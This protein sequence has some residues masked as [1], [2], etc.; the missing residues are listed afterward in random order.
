MKTVQKDFGAYGLNGCGSWI[1]C[2]FYFCLVFDFKCFFFMI[3]VQYF[4]ILNHRLQKWCER[5]ERRKWGSERKRGVNFPCLQYKPMVW[6][7]FLTNY[8]CQCVCLHASMGRLQLCTVC[9]WSR[10]SHWIWFSARGGKLNHFSRLLLS[11]PSQREITQS[12]QPHLHAQHCWGTTR[13]T[14]RSETEKIRHV[15]DSA[16]ARQLQLKACLIKKRR[17]QRLQQLHA[18]RI[19]NS[20]RGTFL[21]ILFKYDK[22]VFN[23]H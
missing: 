5:C 3:V 17:K 22:P 11:G 23:G 8:L 14:N 21:N 7:P 15:N 4:S 19:M 13:L 1:S 16:Y 2:T 10:C 18:E 12:M 6:C 9:V 20:F